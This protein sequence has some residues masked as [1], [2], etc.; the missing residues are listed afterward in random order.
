MI[1]PT[2]SPT[3]TREKKRRSAVVEKGMFL[4]VEKFLSFEQERRHPGRIALI[5]PPRELDEGVALA[6]GS[7]LRDFYLRHRE[8]LIQLN[9]TALLR[10][11]RRPVFRKEDQ[12]L[13]SRS[14]HCSARTLARTGRS[15]LFR[16]RLCSEN[17][18]P[19]RRSH[20][21]ADVIVLVV[22]P[23]VIFF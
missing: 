4:L 15:T 18:I 13:T 5:D 14:V 1:R 7:D 11:I 22:V 16:R 17:V 23:Q 8:L 3:R 10:S 6:L 20:P 19:E 2:I 21:E 9:A 12:T